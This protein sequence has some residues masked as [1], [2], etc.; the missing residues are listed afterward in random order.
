M[1]TALHEIIAAGSRFYNVPVEILKGPIREQRI[2][3]VRFSIY[4]ACRRAGYTYSRIGK[5]IN[6]DHGS[7]LHGVRYCC[8]EKLFDMWPEHERFIESVKA[9]APMGAREVVIMTIDQQLTE[10]DA[11]IALLNQDK[12][13]LTQARIACQL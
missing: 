8:K 5:A 9:F 11:R 3:H 7:V 1:K 12:E 10:I 4:A 6:R 2:A 13:R